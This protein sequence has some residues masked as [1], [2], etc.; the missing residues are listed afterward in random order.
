MK[1]Q[2]IGTGA[3]DF[4]PLLET[5]Y[6]H[7]LNDDARRSCS[8]LVDGHVLID[9]GPHT[10]ESLSIQGIPLTDI[11]ALLL[12]HLHMDHYQ[13]DNIR[14]VA[15]SKGELLMVYAH[16]AAYS[17]LKEELAEANV[18]IV[19]LTYSKE[20]VL[21]CGMKITALP[22]NHTCC[23]CHY[24]IEK[25]DKKFYYATDG[26]WIICEAFYHLKD[27]HLDMIVL[28]ATVGDYEGDYRVAEH[29]SIPMIRLMLK[30]FDKFQVC[31]AHT[32]VVLTHIAPTLHLRHAI[33]AENMAKENMQVA[34]D[35]LTV[36]F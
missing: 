17:Q 28:D 18:E 31:D 34:Y 13:P 8:A 6:K 4:S 23:P 29:N 21:E 5:E 11:D 22:A 1:I 19:P 7:C 20:K 30:S 2:F 35:G 36:K 9:C 24:Y 33:T 16:E 14:T 26:A 3:A 32:K 12:T 27:S 15:A 25:D 10:L